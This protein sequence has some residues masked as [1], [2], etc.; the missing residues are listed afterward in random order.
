MG[1]RLE[2][3]KKA[4]SIVSVIIDSGLLLTLV[5]TL[6]STRETQASMQATQQA[7]QLT[8]TSMISRLDKMDE[9]IPL[10]SPETTRKVAVLEAEVSTLKRDREEMLEIL[11]RLDDRVA[12]LQEGQR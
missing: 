3:M 4:P 2:E 12:K 1:S 8:Q 5:M 9:Q 6:T 11:R 10:P 7:M